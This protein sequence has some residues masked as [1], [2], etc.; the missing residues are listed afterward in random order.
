MHQMSVQKP[1]D[2]E[3]EWLRQARA[4]DTSAFDQLVKPFRR[5][6][7]THCYRMLGSPFDAD[8][9]LQETLLAAWRGLGPSRRAVRPAHG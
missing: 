5:R 1:A 6:L 9:A 2:P 8:D 4:G 7:H 3:S